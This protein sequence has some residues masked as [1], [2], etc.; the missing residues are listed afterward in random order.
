MVKYWLRVTDEKNWEAV[1]RQKVWGVSQKNQRLLERTEKGDVLVFYVKPKR[2]AGSFKII[3]EPF[4][5]E[6][7]FF[8]S[9]K[10]AK[11]EIFPHRVKLEPMIIPKEPIPFEELIPKLRFIVNKEQW[12]SYLRKAMTWIAMESYEVI[13]QALK[14]QLEGKR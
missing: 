8:S 10:F 9:T 13:R 6:E 14:R 5:S 1:K 11:E 7:E 3:S 4:E 2:I 12:R